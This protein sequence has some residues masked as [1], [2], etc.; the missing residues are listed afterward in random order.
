ML[1]SFKS[2]LANPLGTP[3]SAPKLFAAV[4]LFLFCL[5]VWGSILKRMDI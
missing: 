2:W 3:M 1:T 4:G 5:I